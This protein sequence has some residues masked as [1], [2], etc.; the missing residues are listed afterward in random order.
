MARISELMD[1][2]EMVAPKAWAESWD[3]CG[4]QIGDPG[5][6]TQGILVALE[7]NGDV[8]D[9]AKQL[10]A[11][12]I[13]THHPFIFKA[14]PTIRTDQVSGRTIRRLLAE[15]IALFVMHTNYDRAP[16][17][18]NA[19]LAEQIGIVDG[20]VL[21]Q[22]KDTMTKLVVYI[23]EGHED[24]VRE[25]IF[26]AGAGQ[27]GRYSH[28][29]FQSQGQ[30]TFLPEEG[31]QPFIG[32]PGKLESVKETRLE[33]VFPAALRS[34]VVGAMLNAHPYEEVAFELFPLSLPAGPEGLGKIG[35]LEQPVL[36]QDFLQHIKTVFHKEF[37]PVGGG[38]PPR[39]VK[40]AAV[41][42]GAGTGLLE[43]AAFQ[44]ADVYLTGDIKH[45]DYRRGEELGLTLIDIGH[46]SSETVGV[47]HLAQTIE[48]LLQERQTP[49]RVG[50]S[51]VLK[52]SYSLA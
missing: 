32:E 49:V 25:A 21:E 23:P 33:T 4:L 40:K 5:M 43:T 44:G 17:G 22:T 2:F 46:Y 8:I 13:L 37:I 18:M 24:Q 28:C 45:H 19:F 29:A 6:E 41:I 15:N 34:K 39:T 20:R 38:K 48:K 9:E 3:N 27:I 36:W 50:V 12:L 26:Q 31:T 42:S 52:E 51:K 10:G 1:I 35:R 7:L 11:D 30:G 14:L 47:T 16:E